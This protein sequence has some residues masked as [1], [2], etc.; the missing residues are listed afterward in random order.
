MA[1]GGFLVGSVMGYDSV[2]AKCAP[3]CTCARHTARRPACPEGCTCGRHRPFSVERRANISTGLVGRSKKA[4]PCV[5]GCKCRKHALRNSGQFKKGSAVRAGVG[6]ADATKKVLKE[7]STVH[8]YAGTPT[9]SS[10]RSMRD[11]CSNPR[12]ISYPYYG[13]RGVTVCARWA[14]F[15]AFLEDMGERPAKTT[16]DRI[17]TYGNYE[18]GNCRWATRSQQNANQRPRRKKAK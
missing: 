3:G 13:A 17:D 2:M 9:Y 8:G 12:S 1:G 14:K 6:H 16:L 15:E 7:K 11:R 4:V 10:W 5:E 18:P